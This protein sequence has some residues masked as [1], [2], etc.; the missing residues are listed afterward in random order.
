MIFHVLI[1]PESFHVTRAV[2]TV[3]FTG[4]FS[5]GIA[6]RT[7]VVVSLG[8]FCI[9]KWYLWKEDLFCDSGGIIRFNI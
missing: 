7:F 2:G 5:M 1:G 8:R 6:F 9:W 3:H 4:K